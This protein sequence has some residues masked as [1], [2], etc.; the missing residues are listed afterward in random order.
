MADTELKK[1]EETPSLRDKDYR[2]LLKIS[3]F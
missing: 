1:M 2:T 3:P